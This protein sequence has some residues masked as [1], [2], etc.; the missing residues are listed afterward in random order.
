MAPAPAAL[1]DVAQLLAAGA[2]PSIREAAT[3]VSPLDLVAHCA[4][5]AENV[6]VRPHFKAPFA[7]DATLG[8]RLV[9]ALVEGGAEVDEVDPQG[10]TALQTACTVGS[11]GNVVQA[12][13]DAGADAR[14]PCAGREFLPSLHLAAYGGNPGALRVLT[15][16]PEYGDLNELGP[17]PDRWDRCQSANF[18]PR[19]VYSRPLLQ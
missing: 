4:S 17:A 16:R 3:N 15:G 6:T 11:Y 7:R 10:Y 2:D 18:L 5:A 14:A 8:P 9:R 19:N 12:L 1:G 13:L